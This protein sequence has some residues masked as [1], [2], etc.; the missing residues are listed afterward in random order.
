MKIKP[1]RI[2]ARKGCA[3]EFKLYKS[4]DK[5]CSGE[6]FW[7]DQN[8][9]PK[10][11]KIQAPIR[12]HSEKRKSESHLYSKKRKTFLLK[13]ENKYC[14]VASHIFNQVQLC[15]EVHHKAGRKGKLLNY[16]PLWLAVCRDG[17]NWIHDNPKEAYQLGF[18][19]RST[20]VNL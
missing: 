17:H 18:L 12:Q 15:A 11:N 9:K 14:P 8:D 16:V 5:H 1:T 3:T 2:C 19:I 7:L 4:T 6:C 13:P 10:E 20:T